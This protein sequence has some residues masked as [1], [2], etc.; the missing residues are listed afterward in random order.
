MNN[1]HFKH[2]G[3]LIPKKATAIQ[4]SRLGIG[5][6]TL[7]RDMWDVTC[8][9]P[10]LEDL[11]VKWARVQSGWAKT[12]KIEGQYYFAWL[13]AIVDRL[14][15][16]GVQPWLSVS[17]GNRLYTPQASPDG[18]GY[19]PVYTE[20]ERQGWA[21]YVKALARHYRGRIERFEIWNEPDCSGFFRPKP[22]AEHYAALVAATAPILRAEVPGAYIVAGAFGRGWPAPRN[23]K[24]RI[25]LSS[26]S[27]NSSPSRQR[28]N[29]RSVR[30]RRKSVRV[31]TVTRP[32]PPNGSAQ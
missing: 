15:E 21:A 3:K 4:S 11:G 30:R 2:L 6:E 32:P 12:E 13:D 17:Y 22:N 27:W 18:A 24:A 10:V 31:R 19:P 1:F 29:R 9:W 14:R 23:P 26:L 25:R 20:R 16:R 28:S 8:A 7:D 5:F